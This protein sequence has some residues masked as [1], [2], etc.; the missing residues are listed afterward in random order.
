MKSQGP[1][2]Q[3]GNAT[4]TI[5]RGDGRNQPDPA[6]TIRHIPEQLIT[7]GF[8]VKITPHSAA[9]IIEVNGINSGIEGY[10]QL[11][12]K[13][14]TEAQ[15]EL[16]RASRAS[17]PVTDLLFGKDGS[18]IRYI[19]QNDLV[20]GNSDA[21]KG[22]TQLGASLAERMS[23]SWKTLYCAQREEI[24]EKMYGCFGVWE[25]RA[26][27]HHTAIMSAKAGA[28]GEGQLEQFK[29]MLYRLWGVSR[30][31]ID[32]QLGL[33]IESMMPPEGELRSLFK[34]FLRDLYT[35]FPVSSK[36][37]SIDK[38]YQ[39]GS[40]WIHPDHWLVAEEHFRSNSDGTVWVVESSIPRNSKR[41]VGLTR[42]KI[43][44]KEF[45]PK[46]LQAPFVVWRGSWDGVE[47]FLADLTSGNLEPS[48]IDTERYPF[49]VVKRN[50]GS[51]G[52]G[53]TIVSMHDSKKIRSLLMQM[54]PGEG[55]VEAFVPSKPIS[56][57]SEPSRQHDG[58]MRFLVDFLVED[59][60][61]GLSWSPVFEAN[62]WRL[63]PL[64]LGEAA[65][66]PNDA[67]KANLT[68]TRRAIPKATTDSDADIAR[69]AVKE[70]IESLI[71][72][73]NLFAKP[74]KDE[75]FD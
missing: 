69:V 37:I 16:A 67:L 12:G 28:A 18:R 39:D 1:S 32:P 55:L 20:T 5:D 38:P 54:N 56:S 66:Q 23:R 19:N 6:V 58:C 49:V 2:A 60:P 51:H 25:E 62:Y 65:E 52:D 35:E 40:L 31:G 64:T 22:W 74:L 63:S 13:E 10:K 57:G 29:D 42:N 8:D 41:L 53:V 9:A 4:L 11:H 73:R 24:L 26:A 46:H 44:Q 43:G 33:I 36:V 61:T 30:F 27:Q 17:Q 75:L 71:H 14:S 48:L 59:G 50:R 21:S 45:I 72:H 70:V 3:S 15:R 7:L 68:G 47:Q 34:S